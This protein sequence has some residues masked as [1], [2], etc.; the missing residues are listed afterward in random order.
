MAPGSSQRR[1]SMKVGFVGLGHMGAH[2]AHNLAKAGH[3]VTVFD[4]RPAAVDAL[5]AR[6]PAL[7]AGRSVADVAR[8]A[9]FVGASLPGPKEVEDIVLG[10]GGL[11]DSMRAGS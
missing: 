8:D 7:K 3:E 10:P 5:V 6:T 2:M 1:D 4:V 11:R 9:D